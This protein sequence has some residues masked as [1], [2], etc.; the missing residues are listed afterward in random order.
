MRIAQPRATLRGFEPWMLSQ[1]GGADGIHCTVSRRHDRDA[2]GLGRLAQARAGAVRRDAD[3]HRR[4]LSVPRDQRAE[5]VVLRRP[6]MSR[7]S[8]MALNALG[9]YGIALVLAIA[10][11]AQLLLNELPCPLCL[12]Q[13]IQ[14]ALLAVGPMLNVRFGPRP[15]HYAVSLL[16]AVA[17]AAFAARQ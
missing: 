11:A 5:T 8:A 9:L 12:L 17:G 14:F 2:R 6:A 4:D 1:V 3:R 15:G 10:F 7:S 13:R 16:T